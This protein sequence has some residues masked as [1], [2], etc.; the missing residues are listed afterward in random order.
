MVPGKSFTQPWLLHLYRE[1]VQILQSHQREILPVADEPTTR[2]WLQPDDRITGIMGRPVRIPTA[3][4]HRVGG[5]GSVG[6]RLK[7]GERNYRWFRLPPVE[8]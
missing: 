8:I 6:G 1:N 3:S 4:G 5:S 2:A 7:S